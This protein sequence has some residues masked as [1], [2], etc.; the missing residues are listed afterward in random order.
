MELARGRVLFCREEDCRLNAAYVCSVAICTKSQPLHDF[1]LPQMFQQ[2]KGTSI[3]TE[4][5][6]LEKEVL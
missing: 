1:L 2:R 4:Q 3:G 6:T 5:A